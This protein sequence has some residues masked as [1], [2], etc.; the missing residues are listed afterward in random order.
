MYLPSSSILN[1]TFFRNGN[2]TRFSP[3]E[4]KETTTAPLSENVK[5]FTNLQNWSYRLTW[6][7]SASERHSTYCPLV[8]TATLSNV[9]EPVYSD[10]SAPRKNSVSYRA[11]SSSMKEY[12]A[13][14]FAFSDTNIRAAKDISI[15]IRIWR[16]FL[17]TLTHPFTSLPVLFHCNLNS[18]PCQLR[19]AGG[20]AIRSRIPPPRAPCGA[21]RS[22]RS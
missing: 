8:E 3:L 10:S 12:M 19:S 15:Q 16:N 7:V 1:N 9:A 4:S 18:F 20:R 22:P 17:P 21:E 13:C 6:C 11:A 2:T 14:A 5:C